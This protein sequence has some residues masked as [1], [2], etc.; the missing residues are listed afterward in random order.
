MRIEP[1]GLPVSRREF[2][3]VFMLIE[4]GLFERLNAKAAAR[5]V[6]YDMLLR[7]ILSEHIN[8]YGP[9]VVA[10]SPDGRRP[11]RRVKRKQRKKR[12]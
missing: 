11:A 2:V 12:R 4:S 1:S 3:P 8:E 9:T 7:T 10:E 5:R 6:G